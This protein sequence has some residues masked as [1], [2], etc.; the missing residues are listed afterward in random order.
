ME[1]RRGARLVG[2]VLGGCS[3]K[4]EAPAAAVDSTADSTADSSSVAASSGLVGRW[5]HYDVVAYQGATMKTQII[6]FGITDFALD[7][8][9]LIETDRFCHAEQRSNQPIETMISDAATRAIVPVDA[10][11]ELT[12][13]AS[14]Y[15]VQR[16]ATPTGVGIRFASPATDV[17][18]TD[19]TDPRIV[20]DD[21]DGRPGI[22]VH[23]KVGVGFEGD[24]YLARREI[25]AYDMTTDGPD[26]LNG[27]VKDD[28]E[29]LVLGAS[30]PALA[31]PS[32]WKQ[33]PDLTESPILL[34]RVAAD[35]D[36]EAVVAQRATLFP[37]D[38][39]LDY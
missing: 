1:L 34:R 19:P 35:V 7:G 24:I 12:K 37:P 26:A 6:S 3:S 31:V 17:L 23:V 16:P 14:G 2:V 28:S 21:S 15:R 5:A 20:D 4:A 11:V 25:F 10:T 8:E 18:P 39:A 13:L 33:H 32:D 29:Q 38:P 9:N 27:T 36:C 30:L 22:T